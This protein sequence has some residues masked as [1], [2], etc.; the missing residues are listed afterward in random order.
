V[1]WDRSLFY[2]DSINIGYVKSNGFH[3]DGEIDEVEMYGY[4]IDWNNT[5]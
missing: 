5:E 4:T 3:F 1:Q 2:S